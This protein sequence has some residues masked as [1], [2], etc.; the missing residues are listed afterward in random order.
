MKVEL[1]FNYKKKFRFKSLNK[2]FLRTNL[3]E[4][5]SPF[6]KYFIYHYFYH[7]IFMFGI[8]SVSSSLLETLMF[9]LDDQKV[10]QDRGRIEFRI[11]TGTGLVIQ[12]EFEIVTQKWKN[13]SSTIELKTQS[14]TSASS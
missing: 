13:R 7:G 5:K 14:E 4:P 11:T 2:W 1:L 12:N 10:V 3:K 9:S 8:D 6:P